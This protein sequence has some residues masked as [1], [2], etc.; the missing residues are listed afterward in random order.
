MR[1]QLLVQT[2]E[3]ALFVFANQESDDDHGAA[4]HGGRVQ[5]FDARHFPEPLFD[6]PRDALLDLGGRC[7]WHLDDHVDHRHNDL[8]LLLSWQRDDGVE[9]EQNDGAGHGQPVLPEPPPDEGPVRR[10]GDALLGGGGP[11]ADLRGVHGE[12]GAALGSLGEVAHG[13]SSTRMRGSSHAR[14]TSEIR[15]PMTVRKQ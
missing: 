9:P 2:D 6:R 11:G 7:P 1:G 15:V 3:R 13:Q 8:R 12:R 4:G 14:R 10:E 5:I